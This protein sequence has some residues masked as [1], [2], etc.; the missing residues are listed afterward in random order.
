MDG[1]GL[2]VRDTLGRRSPR[3]IAKRPMPDLSMLYLW[4]AA[5]AETGA[6]VAGAWAAVL[7]IGRWLRRLTRKGGPDGAPAGDS[8]EAPALALF[9]PALVLAVIFAAAFAAS[10]G[11]SAPLALASCAVALFL[12]FRVVPHLLTEPAVRYAMRRHRAGDTDGAIEGLRDSI[13]AGGPTAGRLN[14]LGIMLGQRRDWAGAYKEFLD[15]EK[16]GGRQPLVMS[17]QAMALLELGQAAEAAALLAEVCAREPQNM[18]WAVNHATALARAG[19]AEQAERELSR[20]EQMP[21]RRFIF[22]SVYRY[23]MDR[24]IEECRARI[25]AARAVASGNSDAPCPYP[26]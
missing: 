15:A 7:V 3:S 18:I 19:R 17:N 24:A 21:R 23:D 4:I 13:E 9:F 5:I 11:V 8:A 6:L 22:G 20:A 16:L 25:A 1:T 14:T 10:Q 2:G 12:L 26:H